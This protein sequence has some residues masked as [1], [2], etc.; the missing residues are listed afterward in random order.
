MTDDEARAIRIA[1]AVM[2]RPLRV[3]EWGS[4]GSTVQFS[5]KLPR[6]STWLAIE[7]QGEWASKVSSELQR[8]H[9]SWSKVVRVPP[10]GTHVEGLDDGDECTFADYVARPRL[11]LPGFDAVLVD[12]RARNACMREAWRILAPDGFVVLHDAE[13]P[14]YAESRPPG[15]ERVRLFDERRKAEGLNRETGFFFSRLDGAL[16]L[17]DALTRRL[18]SS[19]RI[20]VDGP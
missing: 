14:E 16:R 3:L 19:I 8:A 12:G 17:A 4:G 10:N 20:S 1:L 13:R 18:S 2:Q 5:R 6:G 11:E 7:H 9:I 15:S